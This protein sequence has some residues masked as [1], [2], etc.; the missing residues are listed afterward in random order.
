MKRSTEFLVELHKMNYAF[1]VNCCC[2]VRCPINGCSKSFLVFVSEINIASLAH[3]PS[4]E[5]EISTKNVRRRRRTL[6]YSR[7]AR[8]FLFVVSRKEE[9]KVLHKRNKK[10]RLRRESHVF[11]Q[12]VFVAFTHFSRHVIDLLATLINI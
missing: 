12:F 10:F 4:K 7:L 2:S 6:R 9:E 11:N 1:Q 8:L 5:A 3:F